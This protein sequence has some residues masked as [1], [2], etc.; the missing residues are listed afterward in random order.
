MMR[1][2]LAV[3]AAT[4]LVGTVALATLESPDMPL[5]Q[6]LL[7]FDH[8]I[9]STIQSEVE[10]IFAHWIPVLVRPAWLVPA[11]LGLICAGL[12]LTLPNGGRAER[13]RQRRF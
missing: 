2:I 10:G 9:L 11:A 3:L 13:P 6:L 4:L 12:S 1:R 5:G 7:T 8:E